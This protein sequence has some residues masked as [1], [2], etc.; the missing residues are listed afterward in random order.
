MKLEKS[1]IEIMVEEF[2]DMVIGNKA[3]EVMVN[4]DDNIE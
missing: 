1:P 3:V 2:N 4:V